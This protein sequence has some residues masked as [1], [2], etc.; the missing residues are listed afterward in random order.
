MIIK[1][2][3]ENFWE[4]VLNS[5]HLPVLVLFSAQWAA[6]CKNLRRDLSQIAERKVGELVLAEMD[7]DVNQTPSQY[8]VRDIPTCVLFKNGEEVGRIEGV[9]QRGTYE[10]MIAR[11][12]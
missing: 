10:V 12:L 11:H 9:K 3:D 5:G 6:P 8:S 4:K 1:V 7:M 2:T